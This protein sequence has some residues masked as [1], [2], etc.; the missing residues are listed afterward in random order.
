MGIGDLRGA[1]AV[2][3]RGVALAESAAARGGAFRR[4]SVWQRS[5]RR[6]FLRAR[7]RRRIALLILRM[8]NA[9][10]LAEQADRMHPGSIL[11][12]YLDV[13]TIGGR[14]FLFGK[15]SAGPVLCVFKNRYYLPISIPGVTNGKQN[16]A[17]L[18]TLARAALRRLTPEATFR[19]GSGPDPRPP[20]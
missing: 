12:S 16:R 10:W 7:R 6:L 1:G 19:G 17:T 11:G 8:A 4:D 20:R 13:D 9:E 15:Q 14:T 2:A 5:D 18:E 3:N